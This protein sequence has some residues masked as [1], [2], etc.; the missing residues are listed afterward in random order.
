MR[1]QSCPSRKRS[2]RVSCRYAENL[3]GDPAVAITYL[4]QAAASVSAAIEEKKLTGAP[5]VRN[6]AGYLF[7]TFIHM[8][9]KAKRREAN[10]EHS[11]EEYGNA[12]YP[13]RRG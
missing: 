5:A 8:V 13:D 2:A 3:I 9:D 1:R 4:E 7:R 6:V 10:L 11:L 12:V